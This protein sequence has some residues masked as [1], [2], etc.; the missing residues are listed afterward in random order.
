MSKKERFNINLGGNINT[1]TG[2]GVAKRAGVS[3]RKY[4]KAVAH[5]SSPLYTGHKS[6]AIVDSKASGVVADSLKS[7]NRKGDIRKMAAAAKSK[8]GRVDYRSSIA[9]D[10]NLHKKSLG[11]NP[12]KKKK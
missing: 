4:E 1:N 12:A 10:Y 7:Y 8:E 6:G 11:K 2:V 9:S 3:I 5:Q